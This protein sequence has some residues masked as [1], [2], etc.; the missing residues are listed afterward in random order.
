MGTVE[1]VTGIVLLML[2][3][4]LVRGAA[5]RLNL[6]VSVLLFLIGLLIALVLG[7]VLITLLLHGLT[8]QPVVRLLGLNKGLLSERL[9]ETEGRLTAKERARE[10]IPEFSE[11]GVFSPRIARE[12]AESY[13]DVIGHLQERL[14][15]IEHESEEGAFSRALS[16]CRH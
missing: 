10:Q 4:S 16:C 15:S 7:A 3:A 5:L 14:R 2:V 1:I 8:I 6:P 11:G 12:L 13:D 9:I